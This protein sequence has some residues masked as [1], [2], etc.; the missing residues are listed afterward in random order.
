ME[1]K[2][3]LKKFHLKAKEIAKQNAETTIDFFFDSSSNKE[4]DTCIQEVSNLVQKKYSKFFVIPHESPN[5]DSQ[6]DQVTTLEQVERSSLSE[7]DGVGEKREH[8]I[9]MERLDH[10][11]QSHV[12]HETPDYIHGEHKEAGSYCPRGISFVKFES[13]KGRDTVL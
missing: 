8:C 10:S 2:E 1:A 3:A 9:E 6:R 7:E 5:Y 13:E 4:D 11:K 12:A